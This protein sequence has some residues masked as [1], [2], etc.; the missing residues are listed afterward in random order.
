MVPDIGFQF[1]WCGLLLQVCESDND[2][3]KGCFFM[4]ESENVCTAFTSRWATPDCR[5]N[6]HHVIFRR[7]GSVIGELPSNHSK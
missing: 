6:Y 3:C 7:V 1:E 5:D 2:S 4:R